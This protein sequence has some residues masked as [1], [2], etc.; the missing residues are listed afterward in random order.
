MA[1]PKVVIDEER[2]AQMALDGAKNST[3]AAALGV[4]DQ[5][6]KS[7]FSPL[8]D[9]KRAERKL[10]ILRWQNEKARRGD[11][12]MLIWLG[13]QELEQT[14]KQETRHTGD[15][16]AAIRIEVVHIGKDG[17]NGNGNGGGNGHAQ[18]C[19]K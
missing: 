6:I 15:T 8:L 7:R 5:T 12:T 11:T 4:D 19:A 3:I 13:K 9:K 10:N 2:V 1:R 16:G 17:G 14:D 18:E